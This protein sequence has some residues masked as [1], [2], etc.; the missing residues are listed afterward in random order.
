MPVHG[1]QLTVYALLARRKWK[2][3]S[4]DRQATSSEKVRRVTIPLTAW[5][6][7]LDSAENRT[8]NGLDADG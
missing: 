8:V 1:R 4:T 2:V 3:L 7:L 5:H 6:L